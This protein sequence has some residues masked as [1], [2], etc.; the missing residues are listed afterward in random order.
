MSIRFKCAC[1]KSF[2]VDDKFAGKRTKCTAC[3]ASIQIPTAAAPAP[4]PPA[5]PQAEPPP[6][7]PPPPEP[8]SRKGMELSLEIE[9]PA[10]KA[11]R[12]ALADEFPLAA[13]QPP[14]PAEP[15][16][17]PSLLSE[18][19]AVQ[20]PSA[21]GEDIPLA[22]PEQAPEQH[23]KCPK[24][25]AA[26]EPSAAICIECGASFLPAAPAAAAKQRGV[27]GF[28][29]KNMLVIGI[30][31]CGLLLVGGLVFGVAYLLKSRRPKPPPAA[32]AR[33][34]APVTTTT[35]APAPSPET[36]A[37]APAPPKVEWNGFKDPR[38]IARDRLAAAGG[39]LLAALQKSGKPP[40]ALGDIGLPA[41][42]HTGLSYVGP[43]VA[44]LAWFR[45]LLFE[46]VENSGKRYV[47]F[48]DGLTRL[49]SAAEWRAALPAQSA[50]GYLT[51]ADQD[52][53]AATAPRV[54]VSNA[55][56][57]RLEVSLDGAKVASLARGESRSLNLAEGEHQLKL[58][59]PDGPSETL[60]LSAARGLNISYSLP[61]HADTFYIA[62]R[63]YRAILTQQGNASGYTA[64]KEGNTIV[65]LKGPSERVIFTTPGARSALSPDLRSL[66]ARIERDFGT[67]E[68]LD[69]KALRMDELSRL[70]EGV[71]KFKGGSVATYR[72]S[73][74][75]TLAVQV[76]PNLT[77][78]R[79]AQGAPRSGTEKTAPGMR[80]AMPPRAAPPSAMPPGMG[81]QAAAQADIELKYPAAAFATTPDLSAISAIFHSAGAAQAILDRERD[82]QKRAAGPEGARGA[83]PNAGIPPPMRAPAAAPAAGMPGAGAIQSPD[84]FA[85][86]DAQEEL[87]RAPS[88]EALFAGLVIYGGPE[89]VATMLPLAEKLQASAAGYNEML[90]ALARCGKGATLAQLAAA[91]QNSPVGAVIA[92]SL[93]DDDAA[94]NACGKIM[95]D[96]SA[97]RVQEAVSAWPLIAAPSARRNFILALDAAKPALLEDPSVLNALMKLDPYVLDLVLARKLPEAQ[98]PAEPAKTPEGTAGAAA[99][100]APARAAAAPQ[101]S[102]QGSASR[103]DSATP[104]SWRLLAHRQNAQAVARFVALLTGADATAKQQAIAALAEVGDDSV[105]PSLGAMLQDPAPSIRIEAAGALARLGSA[106]AVALLTDRMTAELLSE[107]IVK[108]APGMAARAGRAATGR[109]L[110]G[111]LKLAL[112]KPTA[113]T[114]APAAPGAPPRPPNA[115]RPPERPMP[116]SMP[117][118]PGQTAT[119][120]KP[121][122]AQ[123]LDALARVGAPAEARGLIEEASKEADPSVRMAAYRA[124]A[125]PAGGGNLLRGVGKL[126]HISGPSAA[127]A[128]A[129]VA[130]MLKDADAS[131]RVSAVRMLGSIATPS[132]LEALQAAAKDPDAE[133]RL[134]AVQAAGRLSGASPSLKEVLSAGLADADPRVVAATAEAAIKRNETSLGQAV[135]AAL[136]RPPPQEVKTEGQQEAKEDVG[137]QAQALIVLT[138]AAAQFKAPGATGALVLLLAHKQ[139]EV[140]VAAATALGEL[141]DAATVPSLVS[142]S[143]STEASV[144]SA[145]V[146]ALT[147][148]DS[149][150][151]VQA[152]LASLKQETLPE[153]ARRAVLMRVVAAA[154]KPGPFAD[155]VAS[156]QAGPADLTAFALI[157]PGAPEALQP[158][159]IAIGKRYLQD[160]RPDVRRA[161]A[162]ILGRF[163]ADP[164]VR[165]A[166][167]AALDQDASGV[168]GPA[169]DLLRQNK[170]PALLMNQTL[171]LYK[172]LVEA[173]TPATGTAPA[174][175]VSGLAKASPEENMALRQAII[176]SVFNCQSGEEAA[177]TLRNILAMD[178]SE[179]MRRRIIDALAR[180]ESPVAVGYVAELATRSGSAVAPYAVEALARIGPLNRG[181]A[182]E[183]LLLLSKGVAADPE[184]AAS[185]QDV[186]DALTEKPQPAG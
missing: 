178:S 100:P 136:N 79:L 144:A 43:E 60:P 85:L 49:L 13:G 92:L 107:E 161:A 176:D 89:S 135:V 114:G 164:A 64:E 110:A 75:G 81:R 66:E 25:G 11:A 148:F 17:A 93:I 185:A 98:K 36:K 155:W 130:V 71:V 163:S 95:A 119:Q 125:V 1:G 120:S 28:F 112:P 15:A 181:V 137:G 179:V 44:A 4:T 27:A 86:S 50:Q 58:S 108:A 166:I 126:V 156:G 134:A 59:I 109:L 111:M 29:R 174:A 183:A 145:A 152:I 56:Y 146:I 83:P 65:A 52:L 22:A 84:L 118:M 69:G 182:E 34:P 72:R 142:A 102:S 80:P 31:G 99:Q 128:G 39:L 123:L 151:A 30:A 101:D 88:D 9:P 141:R 18:T 150:D 106:D 53:L 35:L 42:L 127:P 47:F 10:P 129:G 2:K 51:P 55:R 121:L 153:E 140:K 73:A 115:G 19:H 3:G 169:A 157:A 8:A 63:A 97:S 45:P 184:L 158:G 131:V 20:E 23:K 77:A 78:A 171:R 41:E 94:R 38:L 172:Q 5:P 139:P 159:L 68:G 91:G 6:V 104:L 74:L 7:E 70:E 177:R 154:G 103:T 165:A 87:A 16:P 132:A 160:T 149:P 186:L 61:L 170:D 124:L 46:S 175:R 62:A 133:V 113:E 122:I 14:P 33:P 40:A 82:S 138:R 12:P 67:L 96:W 162:G 143:R 54:R 76:A 57:A 116:P 90:L 105:V 48:S 168:A 37:A 147:R 167:L 173:V 24:C 117:G 180:T 21:G 32:A 26:A